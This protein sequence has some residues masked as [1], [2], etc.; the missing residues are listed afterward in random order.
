MITKAF[1]TELN[2]PNS[3][4]FR[5]Y[6]PLLT[7]AVSRREDAIFNATLCITDGLFYSLKVGDC[8]FVG[9]EDNLY[10][11]PVILGKLYTGKETDIPTQITAK[12]LNINE[13]VTLPKDTTINGYDLNLVAKA[14]QDLVDNNDLN[15]KFTDNSNQSSSDDNEEENTDSSTSE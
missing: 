2:K 4:I 14:I 7:T 9:F 3:N 15:N 5:V 13:K 12:T 10:D 11:K 1:I 8:V 6:I